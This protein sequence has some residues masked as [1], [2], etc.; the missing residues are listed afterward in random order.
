M[1]I[2]VLYTNVFLNHDLL[3]VSYPFIHV[4]QFPGTDHLP[5]DGKDVHVPVHCTCT[6]SVNKNFMN[7][8]RSR[9]GI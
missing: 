7:R 8:I 3:I 1:C 4:F 6:V 9:T 2:H 5:Y